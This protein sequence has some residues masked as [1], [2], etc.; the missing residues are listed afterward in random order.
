MSGSST[1]C[2]AV[3]RGS[4]LKV[5]NTNPI[6][7]FRIYASSSSSRSLTRRPASQY[8]PALG[9]SRH[10]MRFISV[11]FPD[12]EGPMI[13]TYSP[14][15][16]SRS[17]PLRAC[18]CSEP[19]SYT[20]VRVSVLMTIPELTRSSRYESVAVVS[21]GI[22]VFL[23]TPASP[24]LALLIVLLFFGSG[25]IYLHAC[26][27][28]ERSQC[29][30]ASNN[31]FIADLQTLGDFDV[32][33]ARDSR[34]DRTEK[35]LFPVNDE[36][37]LNLVLFGIARRCR[38]RGCQSNAR[39]SLAFCILGGFLEVLAGAHGQRLNRDSNH[40]LL[41]GRF[42]LGSRRE[43]RTQ[44]VWWIGE[45]DHHFKILRFL[46]ARRGLCCGQSRTAQRRLRANFRYFAF[47]Y[48]SGHGVD[49]HVR[50]LSQLHVN[51]VR[52][53]HF[54]FRGYHG[55]VRKCHQKASVGILNAWYDVVA[56]AFRQVANDSIDRRGV[57]RFGQ[58][59]LGPNQH[60]LVLIDLRSRLIQLRFQ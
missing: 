45:S 12:P 46:G 23:V 7:L 33:H 47:E 3:A 21:T 13:A 18:T 24:S 42:D 51:N 34:F 6:S 27:G 54:D 50:I 2:K 5:W 11:D 31:Y 19:I 20:F 44:V 32:R 30:V 49:G 39:S 22:R 8:F 1:L 57:R 25:I 40:A 14:L 48:F 4:K 53:V 38:R 59:V 10:P 17:I 36:N 37:T 56:H 29:F 43:P 35:R 55:H 52:L 58:H 15:R 26:L 41:L 16:I 28:F 60:R 9:E